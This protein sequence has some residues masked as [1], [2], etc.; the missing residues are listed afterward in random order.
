MPAGDG[1][2]SADRAALDASIRKAELISRVEFSVYVGAFEGASR[3]FATSLHNT[4]VAPSRSVMIAVDPDERLLEIVTGG[5]VRRTLSDEETQLA[6]ET[7]RA[8]FADGDLL[9]GLERGIAQLAE[10]AR[11]A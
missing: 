7:M 3:D 9:G 11:T 1:F 8:S 5:W 2:S 6:A 10:H 4:L